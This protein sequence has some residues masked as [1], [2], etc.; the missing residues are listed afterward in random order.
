[1]FVRIICVLTSITAP[2]FAALVIG[3]PPNSIL[4][5]RSPKAVCSLEDSALALMT[6]APCSRNAEC[7]SAHSS[8]DIVARSTSS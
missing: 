6:S 5:N 4:P 3:L 7:S 8:S 1:M 2:S